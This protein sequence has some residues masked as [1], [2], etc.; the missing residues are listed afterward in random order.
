MAFIG[1]RWNPPDLCS[2][3]GT[4]SGGSEFGWKTDRDEI[5]KLATELGGELGLRD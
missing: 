2:E 5:C 4:T 1:L 3:F